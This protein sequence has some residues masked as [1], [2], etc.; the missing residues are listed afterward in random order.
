MKNKSTILIIIIAIVVVN[1]A[2]MTRN[3]DCSYSNSSGSFTFEEMNF[4]ERNFR[5]CQ[6]KMEEFKK[7]NSDTVLYR[8]CPMNFLA[9]WNW[10]AYLYQKKFRLPY[11]SWEE[12]ERKRGPVRN[13]SG[14]QDF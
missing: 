4:K 11:T 12:I 1:L 7:E 13:R 9:F 6:N 8:L 10:G 3:M 2:M 5:M 14:F